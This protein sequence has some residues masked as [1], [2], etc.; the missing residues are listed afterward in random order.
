MAESG[1]IE[2][3]QPS[4]DHRWRVTSIESADIWSRIRF[5]FFETS[6]SQS[7]GYEIMLM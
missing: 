2:Y 1:N 7:K 5:N 3:E 6:F 4:I